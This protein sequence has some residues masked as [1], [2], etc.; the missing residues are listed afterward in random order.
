MTGVDCRSNPL[1]VAGHLRPSLT[2]GVIK[3]IPIK[4]RGKEPTGR[5]ARLRT[6]GCTGKCLEAEAV[7]KFVQQDADEIDASATVIVV[8]SIVPVRIFQTPG[9]AYI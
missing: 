8:E 2:G 7:R 4:N 3:E 5:T 1:P 9:S 6:R